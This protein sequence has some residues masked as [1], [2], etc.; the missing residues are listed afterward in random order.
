MLAGAFG[1][2]QVAQRDETR[3]EFKVEEIGTTWSARAPM[4][5]AGQARACR[6][7]PVRGQ[8]PRGGC[9]FLGPAQRRLAGLRDDEFG[10]GV[11]QALV[12]APL[13]P[14]MRKAGVGAQ[15]DRH[16]LDQ[17]IHAVAP[18]QQRD[19]R[20]RQRALVGGQAGQASAGL[21]DLFLPQQVVGAGGVG[22][23]G[24][25]DQ[26]AQGTPLPLLPRRTG[27]ARSRR[28]SACASSVRPAAGQR[29]DQGHRAFGGGGLVGGEP[30]DHPVGRGGPRHGSFALFRAAGPAGQSARRCRNCS[31]SVSVPSP[32][33]SRIHRITSCP[34]VPC[35]SACALS[36]SFDWRRPVPP[37]GPRLRP[38]GRAGRR[39]GQWQAGKGCGRMGCS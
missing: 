36:H 35:A 33:R 16:R 10:G 2:V 26:S 20:G 12:H 38:R 5:R 13:E 7:R 14:V 11:V 4:P 3:Q 31:Y 30:A 21:R 27:T 39:S 8:V 18:C 29:A 25:G 24:Q 19:A 32:A 1:L 37:A 9:P 15:G 28:A 34:M 6:S 22:I 23:G 17:R